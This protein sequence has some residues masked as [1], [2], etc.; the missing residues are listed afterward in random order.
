MLFNLRYRI[1]IDRTVLRTTNLLIKKKR[2]KTYATLPNS[3]L[4]TSL[5]PLPVSASFALKAATRA[6]ISSLG[7]LRNQTKETLITT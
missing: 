4:G 1:D 5:S 7:N 2:K 3:S 6:A